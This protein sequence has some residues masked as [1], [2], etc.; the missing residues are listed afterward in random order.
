MVLG[1][2]SGAA[3]LKKVKEPVF[4]TDVNGQLCEPIRKQVKITS[5]MKCLSPKRTVSS[6]SRLNVL[7]IFEL[8]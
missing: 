7:E 1:N 5:P 8:I 4:G 3:D 2:D 6:K